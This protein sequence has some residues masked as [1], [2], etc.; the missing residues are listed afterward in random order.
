MLETDLDLSTITT[1]EAVVRLEKS[2]GISMIAL[3][4]RVIGNE[5]RSLDEIEPDRWP[6]WRT[7]WILPYQQLLSVRNGT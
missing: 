2:T 7:W 4:S 1:C 3:M 6:M 5:S